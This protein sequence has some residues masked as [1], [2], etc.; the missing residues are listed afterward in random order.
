MSR[1]PHFIATVRFEPVVF[2]VY[3]CA[4]KEEAFKYAI[5]SAEDLAEC[6]SCPGVRL[7]V[8][9]VEVEEA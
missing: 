4:T 1:E 5:D 9:L 7:S 3:N 2:E 6:C 8:D